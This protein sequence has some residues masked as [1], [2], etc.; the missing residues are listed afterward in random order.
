MNSKYKYLL[1]DADNTLLDF[2]ASEKNSLRITLENM[3]LEFSDE[4]YL[5]YHNINDELWKSLERGE[6]DRAFVKTERFRRLF[7]KYNYKCDSFDIVAEAFM[8]NIATQGIPMKGA[9]ETLEK[10]KNHYKIYIVTNGTASVQISRLALSGIDKYLDG[11]YM[12]QSIGYNKPRVEFFDYVIS[13]IGDDDLTKYLVIGDSLTSDILG[14]K[15][16]GIDACFVNYN[17]VPYR[18][19]SPE[20]AVNSIEEVLCLL[21]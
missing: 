3:G 21:I 1:F 15:N 6:T 4:I 14:A 10:L 18:E 17:N 5:S 8:N 13:H 11:L 20:Y 7:E 16:K 19:Y 9:T 2:N 12:S